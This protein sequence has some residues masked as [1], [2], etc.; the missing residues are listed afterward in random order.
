MDTKEL[1]KKYY[2]VIP[3]LLAIGIYVLALIIYD[4]DWCNSDV[5]NYWYNDSDLTFCQSRIT[6]LSYILI[7][8]N[9]LLSSILIL[10]KLT[11]KDRLL[12]V[13]TFY[14]VIHIPIVVFIYIFILFIKRRL[15]IFTVKFSNNELQDIILLSVCFGYGGKILYNLSLIHI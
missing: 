10:W 9:I 2:P 4:L 11:R 7:G 8:V 13:K 14:P 5:T 15:N 3:I 12:F 6:F 1:V